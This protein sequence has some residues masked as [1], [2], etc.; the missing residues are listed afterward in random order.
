MV[1]KLILGPNKGVCLS[2][3]DNL[4]EYNIIG[5]IMISHMWYK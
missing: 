4:V 5:I 1:L 2:V 3:Q